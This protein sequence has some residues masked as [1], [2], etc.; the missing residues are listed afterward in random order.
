MEESS[1]S[2]VKVKSETPEFFC[3]LC[4]I[5]C[6]SAL[7]LQCHFLGMKHK[8]V[9]EALRNY[10]K[11]KDETTKLEPGIATLQEH[12]DACKDSEPAVGLEYI[13]Q[14][15]KRT[16][17]VYECKLCEC[18][19]GM[20][21]MFMHIIGAKHRLNYLCKHHPKLDTF[22]PYIPTGHKK[23]SKLKEICL[24]VEKE[25]GRQKINVREGFQTF[26]TDINGGPSVNY[27]PDSELNQMDYASDDV[28]GIK[29]KPKVSEHIITFLELKAAHEADKSAASS[30]DV[31]AHNTGESEEVK[32]V[33]DTEQE[34]KATEEEIR[35]ENYAEEVPS[36]VVEV[37]SK[38]V[39]VPSKVVEVPSKVEE[40]PSKVEEVPSEEPCES[41]QDFTSNEDLLDYLDHFRIVEIDDATF[42]IRAV[43]ILSI[44]L[45]QY[46]SEKMLCIP[47]SDDEQ[48]KPQN[49]EA[50][51]SVVPPKQDPATQCKKPLFPISQPTEI[52]PLS[53]RNKLMFTL[54]NKAQESDAPS[55]FD[56]TTNIFGK[57]DAQVN[58]ET[59]SA[60]TT[61]SPSAGPA[62]PGPAPPGPA[63]PGP[64]P[65]GPAPPGPAP[66]GPAPP[67]P[68]PPGPAPPGPAPLGPAPPL[69]PIPRD[70]IVKT[71]F[72]SIKNMEVTEV[73]TTLNKITTT[74]PAFKGIHVPSLV[75]YLTE[76]GKLKSTKSVQQQ[77]Q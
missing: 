1:A 58:R 76:T 6:A 40:V 31:V 30:S 74:N 69:F 59:H 50:A 26:S 34:V 54:S 24:N 56:P 49:Q 48:H 65:P 14:Y 20:T 71:F 3:H 13:Y 67:G 66:P 8:K 51:L 12:V 53:Q 7:N 55:N 64:A 17:S 28:F 9:E 15:N 45:I 38:V 16:Y 60:K 47:I 41:S 27:N 37:P 25:F 52:E 2:K 39:E 43:E 61:L 73:V 33:N 22:G 44:A 35:E 29:K 19:S 21:H 62:P 42:L 11:E 32:P 77:N 36:K 70:D 72:E 10:K 63:P 18:R 4:N 5:S 46:Q 23:I 75:R 57:K 68:A